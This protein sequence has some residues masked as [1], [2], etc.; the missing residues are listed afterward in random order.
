[1]YVIPLG[2]PD[3]EPFPP[4]LAYPEDPLPPCKK[5]RAHSNAEDKWQQHRVLLVVFA[6]VLPAQRSGHMHSCVE[7]YV[8][9]F[10]CVSAMRAWALVIQRK[11]ASTPGTS[12]AFVCCGHR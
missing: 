12:H 8:V 9:S 2:H 11:R 5:W 10:S 1:M 6:D 7:M 3:L 4:F